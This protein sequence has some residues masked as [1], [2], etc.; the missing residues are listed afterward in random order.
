MNLKGVNTI[1]ADFPFQQ[2]WEDLLTHGVQ[3]LLNI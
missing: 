3:L 1:P 2:E